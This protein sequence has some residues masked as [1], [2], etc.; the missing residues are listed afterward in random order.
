T[1]Y[2]GKTQLNLGYLVDSQRQPRGEG[3]ELY[4]PLWGVLRAGKGL[5]LSADAQPAANSHALD[6]SVALEQLQAAQVRMQSLSEAVSKAQ[7]VVA[8]CDAQKAL[9]ETQLKDLQQAVLLACAPHGVALT[10]GE[11]LQLSAGGHFFTTTGGNADAAIGGNYTVAAGQAVSLFANTQGMKIYAAAGKVDV[12][13]QG[14]ALSLSALKGVTIA[15]TSDSI[16]LNADKSLT[17]MC[18]GAYIK[19]SDGQ[20]EIGSAGDIKL[21]GPLRVGPSG[22][23]REALPLMPA[24]EATGMQLWHAYPNGQP[25]PNA[26]YKVTFPDGSWRDGTLDA[27]GRGTLSNAPRGGGTV[28]Y[29]EEA[30]DLQDKARRWTDPKGTPRVAGSGSAIGN[31]ADGALPSLAGPAMAAVASVSPIASTV[32]SA[33]SEVASGGV[34]PLEKAALGA[35]THQAMSAANRAAPPSSDVPAL[36]QSLLKPPHRLTAE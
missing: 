16:T 4:T 9:L 6:M 14:D 3:F 10:S 24:Q 13:A 31:A 12:Q 29:F 15:S 27:N 23:L 18:G 30:H 7:A 22:T 19:L 33:A 1:D 34:A 28:E 36:P 8:A 32:A 35:L 26:K 17:L 2:G 21:K 20:V 25:V 11:H 5:F